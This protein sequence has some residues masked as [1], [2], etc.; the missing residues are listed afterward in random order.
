LL[1]VTNDAWF[2]TL[3]G[4][5]Q[6]AAQARLRAVE[7]GLPLARVAN[8]GVTEMLDARGRVTAALPFGAPGYLDAALPGPLPATPYARF[9]ELPVLLLLAGCALAAMTGH[10]RRPA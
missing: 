10:R 6:H 9:G 3:S 4:P 2:G 5:F 1:Q 8:T 7:Q